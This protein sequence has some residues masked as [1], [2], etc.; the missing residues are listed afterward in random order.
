MRSPSSGACSQRDRGR[1]RDEGQSGAGLPAGAE[2]R[3]RGDAPPR[4]ARVGALQRHGRLQPRD[5]ADAIRRAGGGPGRDGAL[6]DAPRQRL[7]QHL[8]ADLPGAGQVCG[9]GGVHRRRAGAGESGDARRCRSSTRPRRCCPAHGRPAP[10]PAGAAAAA[11]SGSVTLFDADDDGD[12]DLVEAGRVRRPA[13]SERRR[14]ADGG[15]R[16]VG[17]Q[18]DGGGVPIAAVAADYDN[19]GRPDLFLLRQGGNRLLHQ[20]ADGRFEDVTARGAHRRLVRTSPDP[21]RSPTSITTATST[22]SSSAIRPARAA[23]GARRGSQPAAQ[24]AAA[25][26]RRRHVHRHHG[27]GQASPAAAAPGIAVVPTD[28]DNRRDMDLLVVQRGQAPALFQNMRDGSFRDAAAEARLPPA[29]PTPASPPATS[30]RTATPT[31]SSARSDGPG[32]LAMSDGSGRFVIDAGAGS[33]R[34]A[35]WPR[36]SSTTTTTACS[37]SCRRSRSRCRVRAARRAQPRDVFSSARGCA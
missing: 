16:L 20:Q 8:L 24:P 15:A 23:G 11:L 14:R 18:A 28:F 10:A 32:T 9:G 35:R 21:R 1:R 2:L 27:R 29:A 34:R 37:I 31:S 33:D 30:T 22:S 5:R 26:Q 19:D 12:L 6:P 7:R 13:V 25:Q 3:R 4:S 17:D 36:S